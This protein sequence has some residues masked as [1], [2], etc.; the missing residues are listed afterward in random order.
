MA[1]ITITNQNILEQ[2]LIQK[3]SGVDCRRHYINLIN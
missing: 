3:K 1:A 2:N